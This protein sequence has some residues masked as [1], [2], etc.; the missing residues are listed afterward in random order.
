M[1]FGMAFCQNNAETMESIKEAKAVCT[2]SIQESETHCSTAIRKVEVCG[3]SQASSIQ[4]RH[5][6]A[7][8]QL[9][10]EA[11]KEESKGQLNFLST[12]QATLRT[13]P[14]KSHGVLVASYYVLLG[15]ASM[16]HLFS[17]SQ[18]ASPSQQGSAPC[19]SSPPAPESSPRPKWQHH[20]PDLM[21]ILSLSKAT[22]KATPEAPPSSKWQEV[23][24]LHKVLTRSC[25]EVFGQDS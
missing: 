1:E 25:Q 12:C 20:S 14:P 13:S 23:T 18:G 24:P 10:E 16:S 2:H 19:A 17:I 21:D 15:H 4:Q 8:Q 11:I 9:E 5:A 22:S 6:K 3:P 7:I